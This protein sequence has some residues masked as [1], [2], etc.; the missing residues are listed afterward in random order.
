MGIEVLSFV[1]YND[2]E[3][4]QSIEFFDSSGQRFVEKQKNYSSSTSFGI[5]N[6]SALL[7]MVYRH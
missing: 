2:Q 6:N 5:Q 7:S 3:N 1:S 4:I